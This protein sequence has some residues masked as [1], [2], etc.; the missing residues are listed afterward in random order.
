ME[1]LVNI[2][3]LL[4]GIALIGF[5]VLMVKLF[6]KL[7]TLSDQKVHSVLIVDDKGSDLSSMVNYIK[8]KGFE[9]D[10]AANVTDAEKNLEDN[11]PTYALIDLGLSGSEKD[12]FDGIQLFKFIFRR[13]LPTKPIVV[14]AHPFEKETKPYFEKYL[15]DVVGDELKSVLQDIQDNYIDKLNPSRNYVLAIADKLEAL[16][17]AEKLAK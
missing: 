11:E 9:V 5:I 17:R 16:E 4:F 15:K 3:A 10:V 13:N 12:E 6:F 14:S 2:I 1:N 8:S 7:Q